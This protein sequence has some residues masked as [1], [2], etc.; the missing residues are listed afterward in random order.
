MENISVTLSK[1][2]L[3]KLVM[4]AQAAFEFESRTDRSIQDLGLREEIYS[5]ISDKNSAPLSTVFQ[6]AAEVL[7]RVIEEN[8]LDWSPNRSVN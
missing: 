1:D 6:N 2:D 7:D 5:D 8:D 3:E 4:G